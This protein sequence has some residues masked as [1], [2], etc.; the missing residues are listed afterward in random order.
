MSDEDLRKTVLKVLTEVAPDIDPDTVEPE[1]NFRDQFDFDSMDFLNFAIG[2]HKATGVDI[3]ETDYP[4]LS[5]LNSS[6]SYLQEGKRLQQ[7][8]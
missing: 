8:E 4:R 3:P 1:T 2:L 7:P 5:N 6:I